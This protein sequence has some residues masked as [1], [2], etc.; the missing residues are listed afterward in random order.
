M[1]VAV[2]MLA[3]YIGDVMYKICIQNRIL[4]AV[5]LII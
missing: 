5:D 3:C 1:F 2:L 4:S